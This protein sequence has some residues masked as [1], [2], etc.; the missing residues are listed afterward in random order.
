[1]TKKICIS[2]YYGF[3]NFGDEVILKT[4]VENIKKYLS[5]CSIT[6]F[7]S[8]PVKTT[9]HL[10]VQ[11]VYT[12]NVFAVLFNIIKSDC[13]ISGGGSL[14]Q[15]TTSKNSLLYYLFVLSVAKLFRKKTIIFAQGIGPIKSRILEKITAKIIKKA[16]YITVR[17]KNSIEWL[18]KWEIEG[19]LCND[20]VWGF[21]TKDSQKTDNIGIQLRQYNGLTEDILSKLAANI[22]KC[23]SGC[24][25]KILSLQNSMD[26][27][28]C[29]EFKQLLL[30]LNRS[31]KVKVVENISN[32]KI[33]EEISSLKELIAMRYHACLI[34]IKS[35][36]KVLPLSYDSKVANLAKEF[37][38]EYID[39]NLKNID[40][41]IFLKFINK[42]IIYPTEK[43]NSMSFDFETMLSHI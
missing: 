38:L 9:A 15:D 17:D 32:E 3:D 34:G 42:D 19:N 5:D 12:F 8:N 40:E 21:D 37:D 6:V 29:Y 4:L 39:L 10:G 13:L 31:L 41:E 36:I 25:I 18:K 24:E 20:P 35:G 33:I 28:I 1:M 22:S 23:Y 11:S 30:A 2:G 16:E 26:L 27:K 14:L 7:S 43:I